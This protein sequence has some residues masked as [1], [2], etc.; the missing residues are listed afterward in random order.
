MLKNT[1]ELEKIDDLEYIGAFCDIGHLKIHD[2]GN[3][4]K[5]YA[6]RDAVLSL[7]LKNLFCY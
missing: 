2:M 7:F 3:Q 5:G 4:S 1:K 6:P